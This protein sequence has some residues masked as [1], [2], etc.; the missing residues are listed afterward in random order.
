MDQRE[1]GG[2][3]RR[4]TLRTS[5]SQPLVW[6][7]W[8]QHELIAGFQYVMATTDG[9]AHWKQI[10]PD[11]AY[12]PGVT[13]PPDSAT[14]PPDAPPRGA[15]ES[16]SASHGGAG[17]DLGRHEQRADQGDARPRQDVERR[18]DPEP[19]ESRARAHLGRSTR[20]TSTRRRRTPPS[21]SCAP[22]TTRR[23]ST[24][25]TT[26]ARRGRGSSTACRTDQPSGSF[27]RVIRADPKRAGL[28]FAGTES[29]MYVSFDD[30]D[31]WQ[32]LQ[33]NL[34]DHVVPRHRDQG[35]RS[36][37]RH[38]RP[39]HLGARRLRGAAA[40]DAGDRAGAG[41]PLQARSRGARAPQRR[42]T[43]RPSRPRCRTRSIRR[44]ARS[45][46][47]GSRRSRRATITIDVLDAAGARRAPPV[48]RRAARR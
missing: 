7:P 33:L 32:S 36:R 41:A 38:V 48:E 2:E 44:T 11:L 12:P 43:T 21:T 25:R 22:A 26:T 45:S 37:R 4:V 42:A 14:P 17:H 9:G 8:N 27:A 18:H 5:F 1:P 31:D 46:T 10:S 24:A 13:P 35:Q 29:G 6:A 20:R 23:T 19:P 39:R 34:P 47:T 30:G 40:D 28:L 3:H 16:I 15:I